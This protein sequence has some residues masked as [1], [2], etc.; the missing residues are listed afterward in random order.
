MASKKQTLKD[1]FS[2]ATTYIS[3][4]FI[5][6]VAEAKFAK[7]EAN[8]MRFWTVLRSGNMENAYEGVTNIDFG[9]ENGLDVNDRLIQIV[10]DPT[11]PTI[12]EQLSFDLTEQYQFNHLS[13]YSF[14]EYQEGKMLIAIDRE[15]R[16]LFDV[17]LKTGE[18]KE[19]SLPDGL[20]NP[21]IS[22]IQHFGA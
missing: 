15:D 5:E 1:V 19:F 13:I 11:K 9:F 12:E 16:N 4:L 3:S 17:N 8:Q 22:S 6:A 14:E 18:V 20:I 2:R 7:K 10:F 21:R